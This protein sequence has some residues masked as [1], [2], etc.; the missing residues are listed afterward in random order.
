M[1]QAYLGHRD[2]QNTL[3]RPGATAIQGVFSRLWI[4]TE[5]PA[6]ILLR[7]TAL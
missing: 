4:V 2:I 1:I 6:A 5:A 3:H 7:C